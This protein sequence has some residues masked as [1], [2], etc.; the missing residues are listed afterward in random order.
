MSHPEVIEICWRYDGA[1]A[2]DRL[3][4]TSVEAR[5]ALDAGNDGFAGLVDTDEREVHRVVSISAADLGLAFDGAPPAQE[6][7]AAVLGCADAR[8]P[9]D[10]VFGQRVNS[11]FTVRVAGNV[12][13]TECAGSLDY[14]V[15]HLST[16]RLVV[17][18][19]HT[20]CGAVAAAVDGYLDPSGYLGVAANLPLRSIVDALTPAVRG[21]D[22]ALRTVHGDEVVRHPGY[23]VALT[24][25]A[26]VLHAALTAD[27]TRQ[28]FTAHLDHI[29]VAWG[30]YDLTTRRVGAPGADEWI[31]GL[32]A[33][34]HGV[35][36]FEAL[37]RDLA[38]SAHVRD[39]LS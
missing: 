15:E 35:A 22:V 26:V 36:E 10:L 5:D 38:S 37:A 21:A 28:T 30:V 12:L 14:A 25:A 39:Q 34:P 19:G 32:R 9:V 33:A 7:F 16:M 6:P 24:D 18:M 4:A 20:R 1:A 11:L 29:D 23:R 8:V 13:G 2:D 31:R 27:V 17:V 3:P